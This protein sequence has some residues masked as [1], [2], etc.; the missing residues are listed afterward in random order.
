MCQ[1][2]LCIFI[3]STC[4]ENVFIYNLHVFTYT[5]RT[6][7]KKMIVIMIT[8]RAPNMSLLIYGFIMS[9]S[10]NSTAIK[11]LVTLAKENGINFNDPR[12]TLITDQGSALLKAWRESFS[13]TFHILCARHLLKLLLKVPQGP[14]AQHLYWD[15]R[16]AKTAVKYN[17]IMITMQDRFPKA[18]AYLASVHENW[19]LFKAVESDHRLYDSQS[20]NLVEQSFSWTLE[21]REYPPYHYLKGRTT[22]IP[23]HNVIIM[24]QNKM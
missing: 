17:A 4:I 12:F 14:A 11:K 22:C 10:E 5:G 2:I 15:A 20:S 18:H 16:N 9:Y 6:M 13:L 21:E 1:R 7:Y 3:H 24:I 19:Q 8:G 23:I